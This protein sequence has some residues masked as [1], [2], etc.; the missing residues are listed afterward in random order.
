MIRLAFTIVTLLLLSSAAHSQK[1]KEL[2]YQ[3]SVKENLLENKFTF[4]MINKQT[5]TYVDIDEISIYDSEDNLL[6]TDLI[7]G[8]SSQAIVLLNKGDKP[9]RASII[10]NEKNTFEIPLEQNKNNLHMYFIIAKLKS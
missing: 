10:I 4:R 1:I 9:V 6:N 8:A 7:K 2:R 3:G 5:S